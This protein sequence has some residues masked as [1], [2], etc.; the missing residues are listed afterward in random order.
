MKRCF[1]IAL[2]G[3]LSLAAQAQNVGLH[4]S[5]ATGV[6]AGFSEE[7]WQEARATSFCTVEYRGLAGSGSLS[8]LPGFYFVGEKDERIDYLELLR[9]G[10]PITRLNFDPVSQVT[11]PAIDVKIVN[12]SPKPVHFSEARL[13]VKRSVSDPTPLP[14]IEGGYDQLFAI[15]FRNEGWDE[16]DAVVFD[17]AFRAERPRDE[18]DWTPPIFHREFH[19]VREHL[20]VVVAKELV[21]AKVIS[22]QLA[23]LGNALLESNKTEEALERALTE[24][25]ADEDPK[26]QAERDRADTLARQMW[27]LDGLPRDAEPRVTWMFGTLKLAW[28]D[29]G[30]QK[31]MTLRFA[32]PVLLLPPDGLGAPA[33]VSGKYEVMLRADGE[34][35]E[36]SVPM[37]SVVPPG[38]VDHFLIT[39]GVP[40]TSRHELTVVLRS[41]EQVETTSDPVLID[42]LLPRGT[43]EELARQASAQAEE[44]GGESGEGKTTEP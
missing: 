40:R 16:I 4:L 3:W 34:G 19:R 23:S 25:Q 1:L 31:I 9:K 12:N 30:D 5:A 26:V 41:T 42:A 22:E 27:E 14:R 17:F 37:T 15:D 7:D 39:L 36:L 6:P 38:G 20:Q 8:I 28:K 43:A 44:A 21:Q 2:F 33:P 29:G 18:K 10:G 35:Y 24:D 13:K 32:C 11:F